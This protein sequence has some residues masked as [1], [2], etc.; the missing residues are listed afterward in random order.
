[1]IQEIKLNENTSIYKIKYDFTYSKKSLLDRAYQTIKLKKTHKID[2][3]HFFYIPFRCNEIDHINDL[4]LKH[5]SKISNVEYK[6]WAVQNWIYKM[7]YH[8]N[9][10]IFHTH[11]NLIE[12]DDRIN[13]SWTFCLYVQVPKNISGDDGKI[14]FKTSDS[15]EHLFLPEEG[16]LYLFP[17]D[18]EHTPKLIK[19]SEVDRIVI[20]GNIS[21]DPLLNIKKIM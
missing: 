18:L 8:T 21:L 7:D 1:M 11:V 9:R 4:V 10:E 6:E 14:V 17:A 20:A 15:N 2:I 13:S 12:G 5:C 19:Q 16:D 3:E